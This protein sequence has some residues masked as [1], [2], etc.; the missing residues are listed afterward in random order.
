[1]FL[2]EFAS[3]R[4]RKAHMRRSIQAREDNCRACRDK[5]K[6]PISFV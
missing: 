1:M 4:D 6:A 3:L 2:K 5:N